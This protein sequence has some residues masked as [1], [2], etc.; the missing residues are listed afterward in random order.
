MAKDETLY[1]SHDFNA[2][3]D[4]KMEV[5]IADKGLEGY[6]RYFI[7][8]EIMR[9][10]DDY[11]IKLDK[12]T[13]GALA[14]ELK[15]S[16]PDVEIFINELV[17]DYELF[18]IEGEYLYSNSFLRRMQKYEDKCR[19]QRE[20]IEKRW[21]KKRAEEQ[22]KTEFKKAAEQAAAAQSPPEEPPKEPEPPTPPNEKPEIDENSPDYVLTKLLIDLML[23][24][25]PKAKVPSDISKWT[26]NID[27]MIRLDNYSP[28]EIKNMIEW[29][30]ADNFWRGNI[31]STEKLR[32]KA[33]TLILQ[34]G[35]KKT[36]K[37]DNNE[38][39]NPFYNIGKKEGI[40]E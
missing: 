28:E 14:I 10:S 4:P 19:K 35:G 13:L 16:K 8:I 40:F 6:A 23:Q 5:L 36:T 3:H 30:Q 24:N 18:K 25:N 38:S 9:G 11:G 17:N 39:N 7:L 12:I 2:R 31:L 37:Q 22:A 21:E 26:I 15:M 33:G 1:F 29:C 34:M 27:R 20:N 32:E